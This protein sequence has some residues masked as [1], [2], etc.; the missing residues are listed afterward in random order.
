MPVR[1]ATVKVS[2]EKVSIDI[3][4]VKLEIVMT[5]AR[6]FLLT[7]ILTDSNVCVKRVSLRV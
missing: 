5:F 3:F 6:N 2:F 7:E 1:I 4:A